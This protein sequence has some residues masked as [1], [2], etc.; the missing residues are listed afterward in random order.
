MKLKVEFKDGTSR[1][2]TNGDEVGLVG[3][4]LAIV[5]KSALSKDAPPKVM[6]G[7]LLEQVKWYEV[8][9]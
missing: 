4:V 7:V 5:S 8:T 9:E 3:P 2:F 6:G 1:E